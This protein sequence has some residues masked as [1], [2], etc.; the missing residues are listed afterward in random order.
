MRSGVLREREE[1]KNGG[2][3]RVSSSN[4]TKTYG[5]STMAREHEE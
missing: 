2:A 3:L 4:E 5:K 1:A